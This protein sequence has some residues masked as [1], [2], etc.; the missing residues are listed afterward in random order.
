MNEVNL[1]CLGC[2]GPVCRARPG[3]VLA[4]SCRCG[5]YAPVLL[6]ADNQVAWTPASLQV[7]LVRRGSTCHLE[8]W[9]GYS[10]NDSPGKR[11]LVTVLRAMGI[12]SQA[13]CP[14]SKCQ[15]AYR[16]GK[17]EW[18]ELAEHQERE[19]RIAEIGEP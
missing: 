18:A 7:A 11:E 12:I 9:L 1:Y 5:A 10:D 14:E 2:G 6:T 4:I 16:R 8:Y 17:A 19:K 3:D 13:E 15:E